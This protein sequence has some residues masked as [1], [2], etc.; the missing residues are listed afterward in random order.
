MHFTNPPLVGAVSSRSYCCILFFINLTLML[1]LEI[2]KS[3]INTFN[4]KIT[5]LHIPTHQCKITAC[6]GISREK[7]K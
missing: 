2:L 6:G 3:S 5:I 1:K 7:K 4:L